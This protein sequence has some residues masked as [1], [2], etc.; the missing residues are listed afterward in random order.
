MSLV[1]AIA[2]STRWHWC[3]LATMSSPWRS[4]R[5][6]PTSEY[7]SPFWHSDTSK[8]QILSPALIALVIYI[9]HS[10]SHSKPHAF[11]LSN[12][13]SLKSTQIF[14]TDIER[15]ILQVRSRDEGDAARRATEAVCF[16]G[17]NPGSLPSAWLH[18]SGA[19]ARQALSL[20]STHACF[21]SGISWYSP[22]LHTTVDP[23]TGAG[24][25]HITSYC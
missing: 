13:M 10:T 8:V 21:I 18:G 25:T 16:L 5:R 6:S 9:P 3:P 19:A 12:C 17:R 15:S 24:F 4:C 1:L 11:L 2:S 23:F 22:S 14:L 20:P 7:I